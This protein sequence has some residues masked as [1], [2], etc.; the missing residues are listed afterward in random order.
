MVFYLMTSNLRHAN[1]TGK[2][3]QGLDENI[4]KVIFHIIPSL[5]F[6]KKKKSSTSYRLG[7]T[8]AADWA[9]N[10]VYKV[11][12]CLQSRNFSHP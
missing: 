12:R 4:E 10:I 6:F 9:L 7:T 1:R 5:F 3:T 8:V 11:K 2:I